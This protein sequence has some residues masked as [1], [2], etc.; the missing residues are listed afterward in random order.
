MLADPVL[1]NWN[2][3]NDPKQ[4]SAQH[5]LLLGPMLIFASYKLGIGIDIEQVYTWYYL[6]SQTDLDIRLILPQV[7]S[8]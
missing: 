4:V 1:T 7:I 8:N 5:W 3:N 2:Q 6:R